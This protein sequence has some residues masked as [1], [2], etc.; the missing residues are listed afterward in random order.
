[1]RPR[2]R[3][4]AATTSPR[5]SRWR[6]RTRL[7]C[8]TRFAENADWPLATCSSAPARASDP[9]TSTVQASSRPRTAASSSRC[10]TAATAG[11]APSVARAV[12]SASHAKNQGTWTSTCS[13]AHTP[14][15][16]TL[17][18]GRC[19][20]ASVLVRLARRRALCTRARCATGPRA[21]S[22]S[23]SAGAA[24][25]PSATSSRAS[26]PETRWS[27]SARRERAAS[28]VTVTRSTTASLRGCAVAS[29]PSPQAASLTISGQASSLSAP[30]SQKRETCMQALGTSAGCCY[31][32]AATLV[33]E[34][35]F[36]GCPAFS[37]CPVSRQ[38]LQGPEMRQ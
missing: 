32:R 10:R 24:P 30:F 37:P 21:A 3:R 28:S 31:R 14:S 27:G 36:E 12:T 7:T 5:C 2:S 17:R 35:N 4:I 25:P 18:V 8:T 19:T 6:L 26:P 11:H 16:A 20:T 38:A 34:T 33:I 23:C 13:D 15:T 9:S 22:D 29:Q 1:M